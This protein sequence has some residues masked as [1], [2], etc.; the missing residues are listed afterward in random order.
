MK[1]LNS[2]RRIT[3]R[4]PIFL[5]VLLTAA[6]FLL[7]NGG[8]NPGEQAAFWK[9]KVLEA[10]GG[11]DT[12]GRIATVVYS[13]TII[14]RGD[15]GTVSL[16]LSRP[17]KLRVTMKY[18]KKYEDRIL[19]ENRGWR[20]FGDGFQEAAGHSLAAMIFQYNHL[21]LPMGLLDDRL[22][23]SYSQQKANGKIYPVLEIPAGD[24]PSMAIIID[25]E[26]GLILQVNG[27]IAMGGNAVLMG[28]GY[29]EYRRVGGVMLPH[30]VINFVNGVA[31][32][33]SR[34]DSVQVNVQMAPDFFSVGPPTTQK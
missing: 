30:R 5:F 14:T 1:I 33:E 8:E 25:P 26:S 2:C 22:Q 6:A 31:I 18:T 17:G 7:G 20:D 21:E 27:R 19:L 3:C 24:G 34:Y 10:H 13:G 28:V 23:L 9:A 15:S 32:A 11:V 16:A 29:D 12:L 4:R